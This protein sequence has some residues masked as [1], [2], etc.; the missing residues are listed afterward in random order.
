MDKLTTEKLIHLSVVDNL[1]DNIDVKVS[2]RLIRR[3][4]PHWHDF[5]EME[6]ILEGDT[7]TE[8]NGKVYDMPIGSLSL[9]TPSDVHSYHD[10]GRNVE[11]LN[12]VFASKSLEYNSFASNV[13]SGDS[14]VCKL[15]K[16]V[17]EN[18]IFLIKKIDEES[19]SKSM[20]NG[21]YISYLLSCI[22]IE[23]KRIKREQGVDFKESEFDSGR[24]ALVFI[25]NHFKEQLT[26]DD[27]AKYMNVSPIYASRIIHQT[28]GYGFKEYL[29]DL[30]LEYA[31]GLLTYTEESI[32]DISYYAG[33]NTASYFARGFRKKYGMS[34]AQYREHSRSIA[35]EKE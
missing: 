8:I 13:L 28:L 21:R 35:Y 5:Y 26:L 22:I 19:H 10:M 32:S 1:I 24:K 2:E 31:A 4:K 30:R 20:L 18:I 23:L 14:F 17:F 9:I 34:P 6:L 29:M 16:K 25:R 3:V 12:L 11:V 27:V 15:P 33:Y 7:K